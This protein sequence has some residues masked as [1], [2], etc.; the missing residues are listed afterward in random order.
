MVP[1]AAEIFTEQ[2]S[3][4]GRTAVRRSLRLGVSAYTSG[5]LAMALVLNIS[6]TG[7]LIE[8]V[9]DLQVGETLQVDIPEASGSR[10]RVIWREK[11]LVGCEFVDPISTG[12][13][14]ASRLVSPIKA[15]V[16]S[17]QILAS[18]PIS[19]PERDN[20]YSAEGGQ[21]AILIVTGLMAML[22]LF[23]LVA[24]IVT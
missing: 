23:I 9:L 11:L 6:E 18:T 15:P 17:G 20:W 16:E 8:T 22:S 14:S 19:P 7:L 12:V 1:L 21:L 5:H 4:E 2:S 10:V 13:V 3:S 24:A